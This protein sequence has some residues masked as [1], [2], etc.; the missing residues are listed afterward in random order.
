MVEALEELAETTPEP[1]TRMPRRSAALRLV[2]ALFAIPELP[3]LVR[4]APRR[5]RKR[6]RST[7]P[8]MVT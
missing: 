3:E 5:R 6:A 2:L 7:R 1:V 8:R 4:E